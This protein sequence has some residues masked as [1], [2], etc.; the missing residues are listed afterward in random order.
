MSA[1]NYVTDV[2]MLSSTRT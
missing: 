1:A 2:K